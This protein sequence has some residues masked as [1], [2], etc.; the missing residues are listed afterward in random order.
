VKPP[1]FAPVYAP[2]FLVLSEIARN[3]GYALCVHGSM[4]R[5]LD[6]LACP[7]TDDCESAEHLV[8]RFADYA[9]QVMSMMFPGPIHV[10]PPEQK[11][12]GRLAWTINVGAGATIDLSVMP[13]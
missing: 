5:D 4:S 11:P 6:L 9:T 2:L 13:R 1:T 12:H 8:Q 7:W 3:N 10:S